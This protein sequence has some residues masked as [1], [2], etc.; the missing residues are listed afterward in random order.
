MSQHKTN[1][2][3]QLR[4]LRERW[5]DAQVKRSFVRIWARRMKLTPGP[6]APIHIPRGASRVNPF[7][8]FRGRLELTEMFGR[9]FGKSR[10]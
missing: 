8:L 6:H 5:S 1:T 7:D 2:T 3:G 9:V 10:R 4:P